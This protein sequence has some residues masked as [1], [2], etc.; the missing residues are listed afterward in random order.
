M[1][2]SSSITKIFKV[3]VDLQNK[4][5]NPETKGKKSFGDGVGGGNVRETGGSQ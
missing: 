3:T 1:A 4:R 5:S 2:G